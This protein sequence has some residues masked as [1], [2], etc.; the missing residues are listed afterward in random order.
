MKMLKSKIKIK[1]GKIKLAFFPN[2]RTPS[3]PTTNL[4]THPL[5]EA[6]GQPKIGDT[7]R[8]SSNCRLST[9]QFFQHKFCTDVS[10]KECKKHRG[11]TNTLAL[12]NHGKIS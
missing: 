1:K 3:H 8:T 7:P 9:K 2:P 4:E 10:Y 6:I 11:A 12:K 5:L